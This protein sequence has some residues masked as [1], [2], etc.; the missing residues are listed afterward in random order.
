MF[1]AQKLHNSLVTYLNFV[2]LFQSIL[3]LA[4]E[5]IKYQKKIQFSD[6]YY[7]KGGG[8]TNNKYRP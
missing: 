4:K 1:I 2:H 3:N 7:L 6:F 8:N 5:T